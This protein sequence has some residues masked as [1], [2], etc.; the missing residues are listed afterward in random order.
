MARWVNWS[1]GQEA[2]GEPA[3]VVGQ[4]VCDLQAGGGRGVQE[5][6]GEPGRAGG[7]WVHDRGVRVRSAEQIV[8]DVESDVLGKLLSAAG[9]SRRGAETA[10]WWGQDVRGADGR[11]QGG[12][13]GGGHGVGE[14]GGTQ[15]PSQLVWVPAR[16][17]R[18]GRGGGLPGTLFHAL[19][20]VGLCPGSTPTARRPGPGRPG[21][22]AAP[23]PGGPG[24]PRNGRRR[25]T[26][27][28]QAR[29]DPVAR[30]GRAAPRSGIR[31]SPAPSAGPRRPGR[32]SLRCS[33]A[34]LTS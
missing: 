2:L 11:G 8:C 4:A 22:A 32:R 13:D 33:P 17:V 6:A 15:V 29:P 19:V 21:P 28:A 34:Q 20:G 1:K 9:E 18:V 25:R 31:S 27:T 16:T 30:R 26:S 14:G 12:P 10:W 3:R 5:S 23:A 7:G 24:S